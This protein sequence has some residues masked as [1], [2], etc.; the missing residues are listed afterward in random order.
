MKQVSVGY[1]DQPQTKPYFQRVH[2]SPIQLPED[3][4]VVAT[5]RAREIVTTLS[6]ADKKKLVMGIGRG[7]CVGNIQH[8]DTIP[9]FTGLCLQDGP[10]G[11]TF[12]E[13]VTSFPSGLNA[14]A[15]FDKTL[16]LEYATA[17]GAE[18][19]SL[20]VNVALGPMMNL[21]RAPAAGRNWEGPGGD[22]YLA[23]IVASLLVRGIQSNGVIATAKHFI[24]NEQE[25]FRYSSSSNVDKRTLMEVYAA[26]FEA[27]V[28][29]GVG[30]VMCSY[31][32]VNQVYACANSELVD[33]LLKTELGFQGFVVTD[34][35]A[36]YSPM[37]ADMIMPGGQP[38]LTGAN[39]IAT[40]SETLDTLPESRLDDMTT[41]IL[42]SY[43][44][45]GQ[46][47][48]YPS[49]TN[50]SSWTPR[51]KNSYNPNYKLKHHADLA[52]RVAVASTILLK[53]ND[54]T[55]GG[56]PLTIGHNSFRI[57]VLGEDARLPSILNE[58]TYQAKNDGTLAQGWGSG[59]VDFP[60][61]ISP[62]DGI[63]FR[64]ARHQN[65]HVSSSTDNDDLDH[66]RQT[67]TDADVAIVFANANSGE[68][69]VVE[70]NQGDRNDLKLWHN[71]DAVIEAVASVNKRTVVVLHTV[72][73]VD[74]PWINH[75]NITA[76]IFALLPGQESGNAI[77]Q[78]LFGDVNP[79]GKL[80]FTIMKDRSEYAADVIYT[81]PDNIPQVTYTEGLYID[82][83]YADKFNLTPIF[84][85]GHGL[86]YTT[87]RY[88]N[89]Q[90]FRVHSN[91]PWSDLVIEVTVENT[92]FV[93]GF[94][95]VQLYISY[96]KEADEP[97]KL[98]KGF[99]KVWVEVGG[100]SR[101]RITVSK[102]DV[103]VWHGSWVNIPGVYGFKVGASSRDIRLEESKRWGK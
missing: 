6:I 4:W 62:V 31:N 90:I 20:G 8:V 15:T 34:W 92:G 50:I 101:V 78:V 86:S 29:E 64:A 13:N 53:N 1:G 65:V 22:P 36:K 17:I 56:L 72:G 79:S 58:I 39:T 98:F 55:E 80:P 68:E 88:L 70:G 30:A 69:L 61:L 60:Y 83:R 40:E 46:D 28:R 97:P 12:T 25:H 51:T 5:N 11:V 48:G 91:N 32:R 27:C 9:G 7:N 16:I 49:N 73:A 63:T 67:A 89:L 52:K 59:T 93:H 18:F 35:G 71:G 100:V 26:P 38:V 54:P 10:T 99:E 94:E 96:P 37:V 23:S 81:S 19:R 103:R 66:I 95:V 77:A 2:P 47:K 41:R 43:F 102:S 33:G 76:V 42:A 85:F 57:A 44:K 84:P 45:L 75:P 87:F 3:E 82:Y 14:A 24:A 21:I 74:M